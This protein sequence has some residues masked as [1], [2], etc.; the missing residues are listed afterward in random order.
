MDFSAIISAVNVFAIVAAIVAIAAIKIL[1]AVARWAFS[2]VIDW[3]SVSAS[4]ADP[5][6]P[7]KKRSAGA[8]SASRSSGLGSYFLGVPVPKNYM[9]PGE[10]T[11][12]YKQMQASQAA[13]ESNLEPESRFRVFGAIFGFF[14]DFFSKFFSFFYK[15]R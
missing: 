5:V 3:F 15:K 10:M 7:N 4:A 9:K 2:K 14:G 12:I 8:R 11:D 1:P 6:V 13:N